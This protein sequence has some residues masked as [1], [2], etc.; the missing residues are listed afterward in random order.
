MKNM[1]K[2][3][4]LLLAPAL[5]IAA[6]VGQTPGRIAEINKKVLGKWW[7]GDRKSYIEFLKNGACSEGAFYGGGWHVQEG[8]LS[9]WQTGDN[10]MCVGGALTLVSANTLTRDYG[11]GGDAEKFYRGSAGP[12][13][14]PPLTP[15]LAQAILAKNIN[16]QTV[17]NTLLTCRACYDPADKEDNDKAP[18]VST[19]SGPLIPFLTNQGYIQ[20]IGGRQVFT[21][22]AKRSTHYGFTGLRIANFSHPRILAA[23]IADPKQVPFEYD[24]VPTAVSMPVFGG[25]KKVKSTASFYYANEEWQVCIACQH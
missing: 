2:A 22:K 1:R 8:K 13:P 24:F 5:L 20:N 14:A 18:L 23:T 10:F 3:I 17:Q 4:W 19:Y 11:M 9:A 15:I 7:S 25:V 6:A 16:L 21:A 12:K